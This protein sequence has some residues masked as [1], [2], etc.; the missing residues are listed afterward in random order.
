[1]GRAWDE[2]GFQRGFG[3]RSQGTWAWARARLR[4]IE[5]LAQVEEEAK[6]AY[7]KELLG[8]VDKI[9]DFVD[10]IVSQGEEEDDAMSLPKKARIR[11]WDEDSE[12]RSESTDNVVEQQPS[13]P[14]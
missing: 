8:P 6:R 11:E 3:I 5:E 2:R 10:L 9:Y 14:P 13:L 4:E 12:S 7:Q 1:M